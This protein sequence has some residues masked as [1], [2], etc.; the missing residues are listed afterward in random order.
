MPVSADL[1]AFR[2][3][4]GFISWDNDP[5]LQ[6]GTFH[7]YY[8]YEL[9]DYNYLVIIRAPSFASDILTVKWDFNASY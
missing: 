8:F 9:C 5:A 1:Q 3:A 7:T 2:P 4:S 6:S